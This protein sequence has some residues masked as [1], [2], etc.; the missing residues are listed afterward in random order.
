MSIIFCGKAQQSPFCGIFNPV[1][2]VIPLVLEPLLFFYLLL[3][4][5]RN[6]LLLTLKSK[7]HLV[8]IKK[9]T[10]PRTNSKSKPAAN[11]NGSNKSKISQA[12]EML[13]AIDLVYLR[14]Y[15]LNLGGKPHAARKL[16]ESCPPSVISN[17]ESGRYWKFLE[18]TFGFS[19]HSA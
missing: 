16:V 2:A 15:F 5:F 8:D 9:K 12:Q 7:N 13:Q 18:T 11:G 6:S 4:A 1:Y 3:S 19:L 17:S 10:K 14:I